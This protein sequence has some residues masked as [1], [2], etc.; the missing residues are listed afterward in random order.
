M[1]SVIANINSGRSPGGSSGGEAALIGGRQNILIA[2]KWFNYHIIDH[3]L[4]HDCYWGGTYRWETKYLDLDHINDHNI[5]V[6][7]ILSQYWSYHPAVV[8]DNIITLSMII[9]TSC[10]RLPAWYWVRCWWELEDTCAF[11]RFCPISVFSPFI[12]RK[13]KIFTPLKYLKY[14]KLFIF[15]AV[16]GWSR[17]RKLIWRRK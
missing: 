2:S 17:P 5:T 15:Q 14:S 6:L 16:L 9:T 8:L 3:V 1:Q 10:R 13:S 4:S 7:I 12:S 11:L